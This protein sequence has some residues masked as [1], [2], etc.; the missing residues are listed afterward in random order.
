LKI[1]LDEA[2]SKIQD[3]PYT[4]SYIIRKRLQVDSLNELPEEKRPPDLMIWSGR[5][6]E[7]S[8][9]IK[10]VFSTKKKDNLSTLL[11]KDNEIE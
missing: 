9:W 10:D 5:P 3:I 8:K 1:P 6:E 2:V 4:L 7:I 11:I